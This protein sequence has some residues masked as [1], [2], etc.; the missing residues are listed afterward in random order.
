[1][2]KEFRSEINP[3][4]E[5]IGEKDKKDEKD[6]LDEKGYRIYQEYEKISSDEKNNYFKEW[7][8]L[9]QQD[10]AKF[11]DQE[12]LEKIKKLPDVQRISFLTRAAHDLRVT[13]Q[14]VHQYYKTFPEDLLAVYHM[15]LEN[16]FPRTTDQFVLYS[17]SALEMK[18][19]KKIP[20]RVLN[21]Y[22]FEG[23]EEMAERRQYAANLLLKNFE[24]KG[25]VPFKKFGSVADVFWDKLDEAEKLQINGEYTIDPSE[26]FT[27][28]F[29]KLS[30]NDKAEFLRLAVAELQYRLLFHEVYNSFFTAESVSRMNK[31]T[32]DYCPA[33]SMI[34]KSYQPILLTR[35]RQEMFDYEM[36]STADIGGDVEE[37]SYHR[38]LL[39]ILD[40]F[41]NVK[42]TPDKNTDVLVDFWH[43]NR[44]PIF[45]NSVAEALSAQN[46]NRAA[47]ELLRLLRE[48][49]ED[50]T[51]LTAMLYRLEFGQIGISEEGVKYLEKIYDLGE[52]NN[53]GY[54]ASR[55][56]AEGE[57]G[58]FSEEAELIKYFQLGDLSTD[59][60][61]VR[62]K[63]LDV[64]YETLFVPKEGETKEEREKRLQYLE[65]FKKHY[66]QIAQ[67]RMFQE[68]GV[69]LNNLSFKEQ[70]WFV[71][72]F[73]RAS[74][75]EKDKLRDFL[76]KYGENGLRT[77]FSLE[78][79]G[80]G[81]GKSILEIGEK[82]DQ[83]VA[84]NI[85]FKYGDIYRSTN[86]I[87][88]YLREKFCARKDYDEKTIGRI[89]E[90][91]L[92]RGKDLLANFAQE[93]QGKKPEE[94]AQM[95]NELTAK[96]AQYQEDAILFGA[97]FR[98]LFKGR[99]EQVDFSEIKGVSFARQNIS[100]L[101]EEEKTEMLEISKANW[102][103]RDGGPEIVRQF[104]EALKRK[105]GSEY[106]VL[107]KDDK[108]L[109]FMRFD[110]TDKPD[111]LYAGSFNVAPQYRGSA[112]GEAMRK[113]AFETMAKDH[114][115]EA[116]TDPSDAANIVTKYIEEDNFVI[117]GLEPF[118][119]EMGYRL[120]LTCDR[121]SRFGSLTRSMDKEFLLRNIDLSDEKSDF[122]VRAYDKKDLKSALAEIEKLLALG[123]LGTRYFEHQGRRIYV[124]EKAVKAESKKE[125]KKELKTAA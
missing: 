16:S 101:K 47:G 65:E 29:E 114:I 61:R 4:T 111:R 13:P 7:Q 89:V 69:R 84:E 76:K 1:M 11:F 48:E 15:F 3:E 77:F 59:E 82:L 64:I 22:H 66:Y 42:A 85:F 27:P 107:K 74:D 123:Y 94:I 20:L 87:A 80:E 57:I 40:R 51:P 70:G 55:L 60:K 18:K 8:D 67:D 98:A 83:G 73:N 32:K 90:T 6:E 86:R 50:K 112:I 37:Y 35:Y 25:I 26:I 100:E 49:K 41:R 2:R 92:R 119:S 44:N 68:T 96:L 102:L 103:T 58:I 117:T 121:K 12:N 104:E 120:K 75:Q 10:P 115:I 28:E 24:Y 52:Y 33:H 110:Q 93:I 53:P 109:S 79:G 31:L 95:K 81:M 36:G 14:M 113:T 78:F 43:K 17:I 106:W 19:N 124:F 108:I 39:S 46:P 97:T 45:A 125:P 63:V 99:A 38:L 105:S 71:I 62:A 30:E 91:V 21:H 9:Y 54:H 34:Y 56:T 118:P 88:D 23:W 122:L 116:T 5:P 72:Y